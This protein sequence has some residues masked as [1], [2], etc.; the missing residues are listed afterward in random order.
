MAA[1]K[2]K[3]YKKSWERVFCWLKFDGQKM[4][5]TSCT[6]AK[7]RGYKLHGRNSFFKEKGCSNFRIS[8]LQRHEGGASSDHQRLISLMKIYPTPNPLL[9][10]QQKR[11]ET[12]SKAHTESLMTAFHTV[13]F[14]ASREKPLANYADEIR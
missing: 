13:F 12:E 7:E 3:G 14:L 9:A 1:P 6:E 2:P 8:T 11:R 10:I 4:Y 5:C